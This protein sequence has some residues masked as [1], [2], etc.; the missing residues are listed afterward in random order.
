MQNDLISF[1]LLF[2]LREM[3]GTYDGRSIHY[4][5]VDCEE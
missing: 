1:F 2:P 3:N 4:F 5:A